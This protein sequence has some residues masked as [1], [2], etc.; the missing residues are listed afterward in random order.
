MSDAD[1]GAVIAYIQSLPPVDNPLPPR[2]VELLGRMMLGAGMF[3]PFA[4]DQIDHSLPPHPAPA[5]GAT[6][7]YGQYLAHTCTECHGSQLNGI[8]FGPP[9]Q[10]VPS[11]NLTRGGEMVV[12]SE[13]DFINTMRTGITPTGRVLG[14][15][16][17]WKYYGRMT[18]DELKAVW[19]YIQSLPALPQ[20]GV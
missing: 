16:M 5:P 12:W 10:E 2:R 11:P 8:P 9:G 19:R 3:P 15:D 14:E 1:L 6:T 20:G 4:A 18:D 17:P 13:A 7:E